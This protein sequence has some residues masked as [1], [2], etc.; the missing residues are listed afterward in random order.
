MIAQYVGRDHR[1]WDKRIHALQ[2]AYNT[3]RHEVTGYT[4]AFLNHGRELARPH[5]EDRTVTATGGSLEA[6]RQ[7]LEGAYQVVRV[8]LARAFQRQ[9]RHY[10]L[11]RQDWRPKIGEKVWNRDRHLSDKAEAFN[12]KLAPKYIG[13]LIVKA[14]IS[15]VIV[16]LRDSINNKWY[17]RVHI[18]DLKP[19]PPEM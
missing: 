6:N 4:P 9:E 11:R 1:D 5:P 18:Q 14:I 16:D 15:P 13:P 2:F 10:N 12:A 3:A 19:A 8:Q 7:Q 17:R